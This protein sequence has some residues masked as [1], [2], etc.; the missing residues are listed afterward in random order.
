[1]TLEICDVDGSIYLALV[2]N[3]ET[4]AHSDLHSASLQSLLIV[5]RSQT[6]QGNPALVAL[7]N[8]TLQSSLL[9]SKP[10]YLSATCFRVMLCP[11]KMVV[12]ES[13]VSAPGSN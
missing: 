13:L 5:L 6:R 8:M 7:Y 2:E 10:I 1:M 12:H 9:T 4:P 11:N 3:E